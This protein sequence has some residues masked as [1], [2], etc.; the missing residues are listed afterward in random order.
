MLSK[1]KQ[2]I[3]ALMSSSIEGKSIFKKQELL[4]AADSVGHSKL[5][6]KFWTDEFG[7]N[8]KLT[9]ILEF[10][11]INHRQEAWAKF[12]ADEERAKAFAETE[13]N[14]PLVAR[15]TNSILTPTYYS[16]LR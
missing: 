11:D 12:R 8:T 9:Y 7:D 3:D 5:A 6:G 10:N 16:P 14:G 15:V 4:D 13:K 2:I 1:K